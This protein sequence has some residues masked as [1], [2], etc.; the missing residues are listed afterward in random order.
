VRKA[1][2]KFQRFMDTIIIYVPLAETGDSF[3]LTGIYSA[4]LACGSTFLCSLAANHALRG[5]IEVGLGAELNEGE[6][7]GPAVYDAY[8]LESQVAGY[9]RI[10]IGQELLHY[11]RDKRKVQAADLLGKF[12][13]LMAETCLHFLTEDVDGHAILDYLGKGF[14]ERGEYLLLKDG[15][16]LKAHDFVI[17]QASHWREKKN[18]NL[19]LR[20]S[21]L[22]KYFD[23]RLA[24]WRERQNKS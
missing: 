24:F 14:I 20:Y 2:V 13:S 10:V 5:G 6:I 8:R 11:L 4:L 17:R 22:Q 21:L 19:S 23:P 3:P 12:T 16:H 18:T 7:Y 9:P 15:V 1:E